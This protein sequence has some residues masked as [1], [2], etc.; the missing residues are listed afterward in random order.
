MA[1]VVV[2]QLLAL[3]KEPENRPFIVR[4]QGCLPGL[5]M[6]MED[7]NDEVVNMT[8]EVLHY[9]SLY[10][11]NKEI[12]AKEPGL[13]S[14][15][16]KHMTPGASSAEAMEMA[17]ATFTNLGQYANRAPSP[18]SSTTSSPAS[19]L[20]SAP[21]YIQPETPI[22]ARTLSSNS[23]FPAD[24]YR[25]PLRDRN[26]S[27]EL[28]GYLSNNAGLS[29]YSEKVSSRLSTAKTYNFYIKGLNNE[30]CKQ[31]VEA[32]LLSTKGIISFLIELHSHKA[33]VR[34]INSPDVVLTALKT[35]GFS[36]STKESEYNHSPAGADKENASPGYLDESEVPTKKTWGW[37]SIVS[38]G[39][40]SKEDKKANQGWGWGSVTKAI[41][42]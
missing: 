1:L 32:C 23:T 3:A 31:K 7:Q 8:L 20:T 17:V 24:S 14:G 25:T 16:R 39:T 22:P 37:G 38:F 26:D 11:G 15:V 10:P 9:L 6:F 28:D 21:S 41:W 29:L 35:A 34:T 4:D 30:S 42:G 13:I 40:Q 27:N 12:M 33:V 18:S 2:T 5:V 36:A 19:P